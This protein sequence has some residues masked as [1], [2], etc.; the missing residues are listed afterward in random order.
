[1]SILTGE[2][3]VDESS[4]GKERPWKTHKTNSQLLSESFERLHKQSKAERVCSCGSSLKFNVCPS[5]HEKRLTWANFCRVRLCPMCAWRR[6]LMLAHQLKQIAHEANKKKPLRWLFLTLTVK[7]CDSEDLQDTIDLMMKSFHKLVRRKRFEKSIEGFFRAFEI[8]HN[9]FD[10]TYHPHFHVLLAVEPNYFRDTNKY[11]KTEEWVQMWRESLKVNYD[12]ICDIRIVKNKRNPEK[13]IKIL[14]DKGI[15][16]ASS[17]VAELSKYSTKSEDY[18]IYNEYKQVQ[19]GSKVKIVPIT[20]SGINENR[21][22]EAVAT[23]DAALSYR[24]LIAFG[25]L[26]KEVKEELS[27]E[28]IESDDVDLV[29]ADEDTQCRCSVCGSN[30]LEELYSWIPGVNN[31][32]KKE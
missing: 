24:R 1:M 12:P 13:E 32:M 5:G 14:A 17:A 2:I 18:L 31:Y 15:E 20:G 22:D 8:T 28:D 7:N 10:D 25:G 11:I 19:K 30:M 6:S 4:T 3:L 9:L 29:H 26:L 23:L 21:T 16:L 27:L